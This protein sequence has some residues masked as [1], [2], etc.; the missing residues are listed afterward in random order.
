MP[1][2][3]ASASSSRGGRGACLTI[4]DDGVGFDPDRPEAVF[5]GFGILGMRER[6]RIIGG[7]LSIVS[8]PFLGTRVE[9]LIP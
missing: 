2:P 7:E 5:P 1:G 8:R 9:V 3:L 6:V 4:S